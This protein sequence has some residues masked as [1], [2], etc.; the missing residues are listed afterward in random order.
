[1]RQLEAFPA[2]WRVRRTAG[3]FAIDCADGPTV[4][5]VYFV[6]GFNSQDLNKRRLSEDEARMVATEIARL[7]QLLLRPRY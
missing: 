2:P 5:F 6:E 3:G 1:M 7:P 4:A